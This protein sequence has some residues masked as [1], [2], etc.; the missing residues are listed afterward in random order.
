VAASG[1]ARMQ[2]KFALMQMAKTVCAV[3]LLRESGVPFISVLA[4]PTTAA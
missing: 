3:D 1:G 4:H 2:E